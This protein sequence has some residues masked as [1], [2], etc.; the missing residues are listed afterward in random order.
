MPVSTLLNLRY[1]ERRLNCFPLWCLNC[2][3]GTGTPHGIVQIGKIQRGRHVFFLESLNIFNV[4]EGIIDKEGVA[5]P[6]SGRRF[7]Y[8]ETC[9]CNV[10]LSDV[11]PWRG[12]H[13]LRAFDEKNIR[14]TFRLD[15]LTDSDRWVSLRPSHHLLVA[16]FFFFLE[17]CHFPSWYS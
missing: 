12:T 14:S 5:N 9:F 6:S 17:K 16:V 7:R 8:I 4:L 11:R 3:K 1:F 10:P 15:K 2:L 13:F